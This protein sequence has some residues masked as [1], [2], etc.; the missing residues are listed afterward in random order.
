MCIPGGGDA[1]G[2]CCRIDIG[3]CSLTAG[4]VSLADALAAVAWE[5]VVVA[6]GPLCAVVERRPWAAVRVER[7]FARHYA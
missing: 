5:L 2:A 4:C 7:A 3:S 1:P 6:P